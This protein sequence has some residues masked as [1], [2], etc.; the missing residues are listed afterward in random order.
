MPFAACHSRMASPALSNL[1]GTV[2]GTFEL[3]ELGNMGKDH[4]HTSDD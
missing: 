3:F 2:A 4:Q 1:C